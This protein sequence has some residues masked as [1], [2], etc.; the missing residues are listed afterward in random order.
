MLQAH[1]VYT[2]DVLHLIYLGGSDDVL[3]IVSE[4]TTFQRTITIA[5]LTDSNSSRKGNVYK[6]FVMFISYFSALTHNIVL[7]K[8][9]L[10]ATYAA[11]ASYSKE[12]L[13]VIILFR[14]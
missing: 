13:S 14:L 9:K 11:T 6:N 5:I 8:K 1:I 10:I 2:K 7:Q 3:P 12:K 4:I